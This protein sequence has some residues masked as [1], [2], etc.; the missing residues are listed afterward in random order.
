MRIFSRLAQA[1]SVKG[2][3]ESFF[4][5]ALCAYPGLLNHLVGPGEAYDKATELA[6]EILK[7]VGLFAPLSRSYPL[8][9][10]P[11][12]SSPYLRQLMDAR[13]LGTLKYAHAVDL[14]T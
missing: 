11:R 6:A 3:S 14:P 8:Y 1:V 2:R 10:F 7:K 4:V 12:K 5:D 13:P 9:V